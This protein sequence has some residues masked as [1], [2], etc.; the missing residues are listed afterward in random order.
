MDSRVVAKFGG[1]RQWGV[2]EKLCGFAVKKSPAARHSS[3]FGVPHF[4]PTGPTVGAKIFRTL[5]PLDL[6]LVWICC[7][8]SPERLIFLT[9][10]VIQDGSN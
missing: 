1:N 4:V 2:T 10:T 3:E 5:L 6:Y 9:L 8:P 7:F